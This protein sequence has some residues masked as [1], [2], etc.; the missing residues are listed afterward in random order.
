LADG[1]DRRRTREFTKLEGRLENG[2]LILNL[3]EKKPS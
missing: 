3:S 2:A 1:L